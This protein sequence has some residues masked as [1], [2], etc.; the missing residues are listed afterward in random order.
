M[1]HRA[2]VVLTL[3]ALAATGCGTEDDDGG[4]GGAGGSG[5]S[6][7]AGAC[8]PLAGAPLDV[9]EATWTWVPIEGNRC[10][11]GSETGIGVYRDPA[12]TRL[13]IYLEGGGACFNQ[14]SCSTNPANYDETRLGTSFG[15]VLDPED[16]ANPLAGS[17]FIYVPYCTG[18]VHAGSAESA[19]VPRGP[20]GQ[21]FVGH[22]NIARALERIVPTF[23]EVDQVVLTGIS[24]G[25]F[26][27]WLNY[28]QV[29][30]AFCREDVVLLSDSGPTHPAPYLATC[31]QERWRGLWNL[32]ETLPAGCTACTADG[33]DVTGLADYLADTYADGRFGL[34]S[35]TRDET[36]SLFFSFG[37]DECANLDAGFPNTVAG[38]AA[39][40]TG[41]AELVEVFLV[42]QENATAYVIDGTQHTWIRTSLY[43]TTVDETALVDWVA[44]LV[45]GPIPTEV[46]P[47]PA[48]Q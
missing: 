31:L 19:N 23:G 13:V 43:D 25:G 11:D 2:L 30:E 33:G 15:G 44:A 9:P 48:E 16:A 14:L 18:D 17:S 20:E 12:A 42:P 27:T 3:C 4:A 47:P 10:R 40:A 29:S 34:I 8:V 37:A 45:D 38:A 41:L 36:I 24:A 28:E 5:G 7:G 6:G 21:A 46:M 22:D 32:D 26:G 39:F 1:V 35:S